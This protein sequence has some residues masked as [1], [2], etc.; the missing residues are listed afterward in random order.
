LKSK[1]LLL[2]TCCAPCLSSVFESLEKNYE[3]SSLY[4][5]PNIAPSEEYGR[6]LSELER[7][8]G[9]RDFLLIKGTYDLKSW[10]CEVKPLRFLGERSERC[11]R[12]YRIR[13]TNAFETARERN[14]GMVGTT[15]SVSPHKN[16]EMI[17][18][19]GQE[20][21]R[22]YRIEFMAA[23][24]KKND[25][26]RRSVELSARYGFYRQNYCGC[27]Y[28]KMERDKNSP[29]NKKFIKKI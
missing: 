12:C 6:R 21:G 28:S 13:L 1:K 23:D 4:F 17:N 16:A 25:G 8:S 15:L 18:A 5:N 10:T 29:W 14:Y 22:K 2:H 26:Y 11:W 3:I 20:L 27:I 7:F 9:E 19:I 24:F